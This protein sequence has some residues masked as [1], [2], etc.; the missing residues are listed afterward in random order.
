[1]NI[2]CKNLLV[3]SPHFFAFVRDQVVELAKYLNKTYVICPEP[4]FKNNLKDLKGLPDNIEVFFVKFLH[5]PL[6]YFRRRLDDNQFRSIS[7]IIHRKNIEFDLIH[8][9]FTWP[10]GY[11]GAKLKEEYKKPLVVTAH[12]G[13]IYDLPFKNN[14]WRSK[15]T[16][17]LN[18]AD[19]IITVSKGNLKCIRKLGIEAPTEV[20]PNGYDSALFK[21]LDRAKCREMLNLP[22]DKKMVLTV[23]NLTK[24][25]GQEYLIL[26]VEEVVK[27]RKDVLCVIIGNGKLR[28][29][30]KSQIR[31]L[32]LQHHIKLPG[33]KSHG[34]VPLWMNACDAFVLPS[35]NESFG[36]VQIEAMAC[37]KPVIA[38]YNGGSEEI[39]TSEEYGYLVEPRNPREMAKRILATLDRRWNKDLILSYNHRF[40]WAGITKR[41]SQLYNGTIADSAS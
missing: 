20:I 1:M 41:I 7:R 5:L 27:R 11:V 14:F 9:H 16:S 8:A 30:L 28:G 15:V 29:K 34:E 36:V 10:L 26:A 18:S 39:I 13:D 32:N 35:L 17:A 25:K 31:E 38:T 21:P 24:V 23:G 33:G 19:R 3:L 40:T 37:G 6:T 22:R 2:K 4:H 12:G